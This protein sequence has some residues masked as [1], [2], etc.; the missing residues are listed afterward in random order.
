ML[1]VALYNRL[2]YKQLTGVADIDYSFLIKYLLWMTI[3]I[4][5]RMSFEP[6]N[7]VR[8]LFDEAIRLYEKL[9]AEKHGE[10]AAIED[11]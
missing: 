10:V 9:S 6:P 2:V 4:K 5:A 1:L 11:I 8:T 7:E 3:Y